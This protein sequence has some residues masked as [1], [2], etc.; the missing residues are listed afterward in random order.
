FVPHDD[1][2]DVKTPAW[3]ALATRGAVFQHAWNNTNWTKPSVATMLTG[4]YPWVHGAQSKRDALPDEIELLSERLQKSGFA[5]GGFVSNGFISSAFNFERGWDR[6]TN[7][8]RE[9]LM[10]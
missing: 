1:R 9:Q 7:Y 3:D 6:F 4:L 2:F 8:P 10:G 5:T